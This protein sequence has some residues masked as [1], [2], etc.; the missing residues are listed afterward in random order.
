MVTHIHA[1]VL[2][3]R[4]DLIMSQKPLRYVKEGTKIDNGTAQG[5]KSF[6]EDTAK[7]TVRERNEK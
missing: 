5:C 3:I 6:G 2:L 7:A 4:P 1:G